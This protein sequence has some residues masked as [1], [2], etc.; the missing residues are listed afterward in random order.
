MAY[1]NENL[2]EVLGGKHFTESSSSK[3]KDWSP[4]NVRAII[5]GQGFI[6][7]V[8][9]IGGFGGVRV[10]NLSIQDELKDA[11][12]I[13]MR[14]SYGTLFNTLSKRS[15][16]CLEEIYLDASLFGTNECMSAMKIYV[17][18]L[19]NA[20]LRYYG[21]GMFPQG[22]QDEIKM[23]YTEGAKEKTKNA[24]IGFNISSAVENAVVY[25]NDEWY[26]HYFLRP[27]FYEM[28]REDGMLACHFRKL[29]KVISESTRVSKEVSSL[30]NAIDL[31]DFDSLDVLNKIDSLVD[32]SDAVYKIFKASIRECLKHELD[33]TGLGETML[34]GYDPRVLKYC[35]V[36]N[37]IDPHAEDNKLALEEGQPLIYVE[38]FFN[39][40]T[41]DIVDRMRRAGYRNTVALALQ[42]NID[43]LPENSYLRK[44]YGSRK[45]NSMGIKGYF[46]LL[47]D[48]LGVR[49][50][51]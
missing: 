8:N 32:A 12:S 30:A 7:I 13:R 40:I 24:K 17:D 43:K 4:N 44:S 23:L 27:Q 21:F 5:I 9:H 14:C 16:S 26:K 15:L 42:M 2:Q 49:I 38:L 36:F 28:D 10:K 46:S 11:E 6:L 33:C 20:R 29:E 45:G 22:S 34:K 48:L 25:D 50:G 31:T 35:K 18:S 1:I 3:V 47:S 41:D 51:G 37:K 39:M 19:A